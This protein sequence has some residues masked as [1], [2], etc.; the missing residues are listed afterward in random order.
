LLSA[1]FSIATGYVSPADFAA[2]F[3]ASSSSP[4][5]IPI[6]ASL[7]SEFATTRSRTSGNAFSFAAPSLHANVW[8]ITT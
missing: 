4:S 2:D 6:A 5:P 8:M 3:A 1:S 7:R